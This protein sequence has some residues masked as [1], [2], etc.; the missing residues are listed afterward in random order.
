MDKKK[1]FKCGEVK[2]I[3]DFYI[4]PQMGDGHLN[5]CKDCTRLDSKAYFHKKSKDENWVDKQRARGREKYKRLGYNKHSKAASE[6]FP[7]KSIASARA[8]YIE[9]KD[10]NERHHWSYNEEHWRDVVEL[11]IKDH[12]RAHVWMVYDQERMMFRS[13]GTMELLDTKEK[14]L[15]YIT[16]I[17]KEKYD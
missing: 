10:G 1:C 6:L 14:H 12:R 4:H 9:C 7:E 3:A 16:S 17:L 15:D 5:K 8:K 13:V 11:P 2:F